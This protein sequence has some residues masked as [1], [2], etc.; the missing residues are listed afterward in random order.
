MAEPAPPIWKERAIVA[1]SWIAAVYATYPNDILTVEFRNGTVVEIFNTTIA[2]FY[3]VRSSGS[4][5]GIVKNYLWAYPWRHAPR[6]IP[7][8]N[9]DIQVWNDPPAIVGRT[10]L[11]E[12]YNVP[13]HWIDETV[14]CQSEEMPNPPL[15]S[16]RL[17]L[18]YDSGQ[19]YWTIADDGDPPDPGEEHLISIDPDTM[20]A[21]AAEWA[22]YDLF[23][24][25]GSW[26]TELTFYAR[27]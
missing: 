7:P 16:G 20:A 24:S 17:Y 2:D 12:A 18:R 19:W 5:G 27:P 26:F 15:S 23:M 10:L 22:D 6:P 9:F 14:G 1:S 21:T 3:R 13:L 8:Q 25:G 11:F 4:P